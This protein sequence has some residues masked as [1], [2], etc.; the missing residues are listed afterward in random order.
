MSL[1][2]KAATLD[3]LAVSRH[4]PGGQELL[5]SVWLTE[6]RSAVQRYDISDNAGSWSAVYGASQAFRFAVTR[7]PEALAQVKRILRGQETLLRI[8]GVPGLLARA[9]VN[10]ALP[11]FPNEAQLYASYPNCDL[12][13]AHCKR[14]SKV[15][16]GDYAGLLFKNDVSKDEYVGHVFALGA[17]AQLVDDVEVRDTAASL[18]REIAEHLIDHDLELTDIDGKTTAF[19]YLS[20]ISL[21]DFPGF[22]ALLALSWL[23][24]AAAVT[25]DARLERYY[26]SCL[27][28]DDLSSCERPAITTDD[29]YLVHLGAM[30]L[31]LDCMTN[32]NNHHMAQLAMFGLLQYERD[33]AL[34]RRYQEVLARGLWDSGDPRPMRVQENAMFTLFYEINRDPAS[35]PPDAE[36][37]QAICL[38]KR[39]PVEKTQRAVDT[40]RYP[41]VCRDRSDEP[42]TGVV[43]PLE[44]RPIGNYLWKK[45]PYK[46]LQEPEEPRAVDSPEDF[47]LAYWVGRYFGIIS[48]D[49]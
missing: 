25:Q 1:R 9:Y 27:V 38:L 10:P 18:L 7:E 48:P 26:Q 40:T 28:Q 13:A 19:G 15:E 29:S 6:D 41:E 11:G 5:H 8:T 49:L 33:P 21:N 16:T 23:R 44:E 20:P 4:H 24:T 36:L 43:I 14:W 37:E 45:N 3:A 31:D 35:P 39:F 17:V 2:E 22:N 46:M 32:W 42:L 34:R 12:T 47:L 30:G